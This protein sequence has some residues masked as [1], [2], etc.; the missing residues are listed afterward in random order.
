MG[1]L[2]RGT[3]FRGVALVWPAASGRRIRGR[4]CRLGVVGR[5]W[6]DRTEGQL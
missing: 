1:A 4:G 6:A 3:T 5:R 2:R